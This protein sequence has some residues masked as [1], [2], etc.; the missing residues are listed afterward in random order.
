[1]KRVLL[2]TAAICAVMCF[3][4]TAYAQSAGDFRTKDTVTGAQ[5]WSDHTIWEV[6][7]S[8]S[9]QPLASGYPADTTKNVTIQTPSSATLTVD[10]DVTDAAAAQLIVQSSAFV[11]IRDGKTL[12][13]RGASSVYEAGGLDLY[14]GD[15][16]LKISDSLT[17]SSTGSSSSIKGESGTAQIAIASSKT[18]TSTTTIRGRLQIA[19]ASGASSTAFVND[20]G[21]L[22]LADA[23]GTLDMQADTVSGAGDWQVSSNGSAVLQF[24]TG[25]QCLTGRFDVDNGTLNI[26]DTVCTT[27]VLD[28]QG[29][30]IDVINGK[31]FSAGGS[32][33]CQ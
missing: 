10:V 17:F 18:L 22:V 29:G 3:G 20:T 13:I 23:A 4:L 1:M 5:G 14:D 32:C 28:F 27:G 33:S 9:W 8:G 30:E 31:S 2:T 16:T 15:A 7:I 12:E 24:T 21:G 6:Y 25:S 11:R 26:L 19:P